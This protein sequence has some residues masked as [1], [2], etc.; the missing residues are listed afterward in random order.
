[1]YPR[2]EYEM[3]EADLDKILDACKSV[4]VMMIG[5]YAGS[6][7]QENANRAWAELGGRMG[8]DSDT[9]RPI[10]GKSSRHFTAVPTE[11]ETQ[12]SE[13]LMTEKQEAKQAEITFL[14]TT[15]Q[16]AQERLKIIKSA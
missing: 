13:R 6:S 10:E 11:T 12:K 15:I 3:T 1:M 8:F 9:V 4:P 7:P 5:S 14:E 16:E 2:T